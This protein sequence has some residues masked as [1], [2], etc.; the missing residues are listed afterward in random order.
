MMYSASL[1]YTP[2]AGDYFAAL[3]ELPWAIWLDSN[4]R[5]RYDI[6]VAQPRMT[7]VTY[8]EQTEINDVEGKRFSC[9]D[10]ID[11]LRE[12]LG[13]A[14]ARAQESP[15][16]GG[17]V[18]YWGYD[19]AR[20][21]VKLSERETELDNLPDMAF[22]I[23]DWALVIDHHKQNARLISQQKFPE[24]AK[25]L[26][27]ILERLQKK[28]TSCR[29]NFR[30]NGKINANFSREGYGAAFEK[31]HSYL[32][33]GDCYQ[34][35]LAQ[36]FTAQATGEALD[37]YMTLREMTPAPYSAFLDLPHGQILC[38]SPERFL[39]VKDG[40]AETRPI[41]GTRPRGSDEIAD[42]QLKENLRTN[43]KDRAENL[44]IVDLLRNDLSKSCTVGSIKVRKLFEVETYANVHHLTS[45]ITGKLKVGKDALSLLRDCFPGGSITGAPKK[46][47]MEIIEELELQRRGL[48]CGAIGYV[49][50]DGN[51][52]TNIAIRT[53]IYAHGKIHFS[54]G[55]G[56]VADSSAD[57]EYRETLDKAWGMLKVLLLY[58]GTM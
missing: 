8:G 40:S 24:T 13:T 33:A 49:G 36:R 56:I 35:N 39:L 27:E 9:R 14:V 43:L 11:L 6:L 41:K 16:S 28:Q 17:A 19:L 54:V 7:L 57:D 55:G 46:R 53:M 48:Y 20:R 37:A 26:P 45:T 52:D 30:V 51:M 21:W 22:G 2:H 29:R 1:P 15:F 3:V 34:V 58:G 31:I 18:G 5:D 23:Y 47:A 4:G 10:P 25:V 38:T 12:M 50:W 32:V 42:A 44:M